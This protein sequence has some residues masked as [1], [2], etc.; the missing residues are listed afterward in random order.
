MASYS[1]VDPGMC[2]FCGRRKADPDS[3]AHVPMLAHVSRY[4]GYDEYKRVIDVPRCAQCRAAHKK[5]YNSFLK[6]TFGFLGLGLVEMIVAEGIF[7]PSMDWGLVWG[8]VF[9]GCVITGFVI[10]GITLWRYKQ[11]P[12]GRRHGVGMREHPEIGPLLEQNW[13]AQN[14]SM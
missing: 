5:A 9:F 4:Y 11:T 10:G 1:Q 14:P 12:D 6:Y 7:T 2:W 8:V 3:V 13:V